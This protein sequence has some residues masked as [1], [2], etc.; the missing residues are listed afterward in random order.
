MKLACIRSPDERGR[1]R[2]V[3]PHPATLVRAACSGSEGPHR[4]MSQS[5]GFNQ[6]PPYVDVDLYGRD[7]SL[8]SAVAANGAGHDAPTLAEFGQRWASAEMFDAA[9]QANEN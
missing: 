4:Q 3:F 6:P 2:G 7:A 9:R 5:L 1:H 8:Q